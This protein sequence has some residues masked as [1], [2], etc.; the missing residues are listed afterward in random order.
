MYSYVAELDGKI[1]GNIGLEHSQRPRTAHCAS[2]GIGVHDEYHGLGIGSR[3]VETVLDL[4]DNWLNV[5]RVQIEVNADNKAAIAS[6]LNSVLRLKVRRC[7]QSFETV[8]LS[9]RIIWLD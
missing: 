6:T 5:Q 2:F 8:N 7:A 4:T 1:V 3:L 9:R